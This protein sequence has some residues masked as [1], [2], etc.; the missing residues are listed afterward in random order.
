MVSSRKN[1]K[2]LTV[3]LTLV[4][5]AAL[6]AVYFL[7]FRSREDMPNEPDKPAQT[8]SLLAP[9]SGATT[10]VQLQVAIA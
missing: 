5:A 2:V 8:S 6:L 7:Y 3:V 10:A 4:V 9:A 1:R